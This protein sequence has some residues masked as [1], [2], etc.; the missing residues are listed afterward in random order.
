MIPTKS[1]SYAQW[2]ARITIIVVSRRSL[3]REAS[4]AIPTPRAS[5]DRANRIKFGQAVK[6]F[7]DHHS[8]NS[9]FRTVR[10]LVEALLVQDELA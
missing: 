3:R 6:R 8:L 7:G 2:R 5:P 4:I 10:C 9:S 1:K